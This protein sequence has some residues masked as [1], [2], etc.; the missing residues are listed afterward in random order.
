MASII[1]VFNSKGGVGKSTLAFHLAHAATARGPVL[2][3]DLDPQGAA[4]HLAGG[5][6]GAVKAKRVFSRDVEPARLVQ[7]TAWAG[8]D[9]LPAD[10]SL[11]HLESQLADT[12]KPKRL[13]KLL[14]ELA[15]AYATIL[16]DCPP[17]LGEVG[18]QL[19]RAADLVVVPV[20]PSPLGLRAFAQFSAHFARSDGKGPPLLPVF[21]MAE[22]R[23]PLHKA[24][25]AE[26]PDW[27]VVPHSSL[28]ERSALAQA[29]VAAFAPRSTA[30]A[31]MT[32]LWRS[33][34]AALPP[35]P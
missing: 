2:L 27:P 11:R 29:P 14:R 13:A 21:S 4:T 12:D 26:H 31:A 30:A 15:P 8:L 6:A 20:T 19:F 28:I 16:L 24:S 33:V 25:L 32:R 9:L 3:W 17:G 18:E 5:D 35:A 22:S 7:P 34:V 23:K 1:A 10:L